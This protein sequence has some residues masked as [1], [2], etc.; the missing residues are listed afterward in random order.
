MTPDQLNIPKGKFVETFGEEWDAVLSEGRVMNALDACKTLGID[1]AEINAAWAA[2]KDEKRLVKF[3]GGFYCA[4][5]EIEGKQ[6]LYTLNAFFMS[7]NT[8]SISPPE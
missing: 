4:R 5:L 2:A 7:M 3:G 6:P 8:S 1:A